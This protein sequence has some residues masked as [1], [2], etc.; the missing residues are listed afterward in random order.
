[1]GLMSELALG[2]SF[3]VFATSHMTENVVSVQFENS[4]VETDVLTGHFNGMCYSCRVQAGVEMW[5][6]V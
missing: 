3:A 1:M 2:G 4:I 5:T 6:S